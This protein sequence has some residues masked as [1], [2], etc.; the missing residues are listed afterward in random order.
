MILSVFRPED[1]VRDV[2]IYCIEAALRAPRVPC[3]NLDLCEVPRPLCGGWDGVCMLPR[4]RPL[5]DYPVAVLAFPTT[6]ARYTSKV[7]G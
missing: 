5:H 3:R 4:G 6:W 1:M 2:D 7:V